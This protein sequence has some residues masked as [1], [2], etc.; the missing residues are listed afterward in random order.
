MPIISES[1][2]ELEMLRYREDW[3]TL[4]AL[5]LYVVW[6]FAGFWTY[7]IMP[8]Y[9]VVL[10][11]VL[12]CVFGFTT[13]VITHNTVHTPMWESD[14]MNQ[15]T[16]L[17][18]SCIY[19]NA[20]SV[21]VRGH[22]YS[23]HRYTQTPKDLMRTTKARFRLN[24]LNQ[25]L[26]LF[27][28]GPAIERGNKIFIA[29]ER[30]MNSAWWLQF[31]LERLCN[32]SVTLALLAI[33][34]QASLFFLMIP[35]LFGVWGICG[36]NYVQHDGCDVGHPFNHS[37]NLVSPI[38]NFV[39]FNNGYHTIHHEK[40]QLHWSLLREAHEREIKP[41]IDPRLDEP[42]MFAYLWRTNIWPG[43]RLRYNG[44]PVVLGPP[45]PDQDWIPDTFELGQ[46]ISVGA[47]GG[48]RL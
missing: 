35:R 5:S 8:G 11:T 20:V 38:L 24:G 43:K 36:I 3:R 29:R 1:G 4:L 14:R 44:E 48:V 22:N 17:F 42:S 13:A 15:L 31:R 26:F 30:E 16:Q 7:A 18:I 37:R 33:N 25:L 9:G 32:W 41:H 19:G 34:W 2:E 45:E 12:G 23:H 40:P 21:F 47:A 46:E 10:Y 39:L 28:V 6:I 27:I